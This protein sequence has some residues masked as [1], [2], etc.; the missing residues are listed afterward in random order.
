MGRTSSTGRCGGSGRHFGGGLINPDTTQRYQDELLLSIEQQLAGNWAARATGVYAEARNQWRLANSLRPYEVYNIPVTNRDPGPDGVVGNADDPGN[1]ITYFDYPAS[2]AGADFQKPWIVNDDKANST[3][4]TLEFQVSR[5][6]AGNWQFRASYSAT[7]KDIPLVTN[8]GNN[9]T[10]LIN[11]QDPN[12]EIFASDN[13]WEWIF[14]TGG[15]YLFPYGVLGSVN[16]S[17]ESGNPW[18]RRVEFAGGRQIPTL[19]V[20]VEPIGAR[21]L[22]NLNLLDIRGE[23]RFP[24]GRRP[25][26][27]RAVEPLQ[28]T[29]TTPPC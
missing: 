6:Y 10:G 14:R 7:K 22:D 2:L 27:G 28:W 11:T 21:R 9:Q 12:A 24:G 18:A 20:N 8:V 15:S 29:R 4:K 23:K 1:T 17:H 13:T 19:I 26:A 5:R 25:R 16:L 3:F